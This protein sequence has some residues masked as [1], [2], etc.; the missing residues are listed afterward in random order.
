MRDDSLFC[1]ECSRELRGQQE[2]IAGVCARCER[3]AIGG[4][5]MEAETRLGETPKFDDVEI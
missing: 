1:M 2:R 3:D 4:E 5:V